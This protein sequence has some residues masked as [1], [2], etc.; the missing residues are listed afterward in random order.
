MSELDYKQIIS[1]IIN[2]SDLL[3][4]WELDFITSQCK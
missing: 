4:E 1:N 3:N 2:Q